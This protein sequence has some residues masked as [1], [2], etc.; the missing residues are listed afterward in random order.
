MDPRI[1][2]LYDEYTHKPL[3]R[4]VFLQRLAVLAGGTAA[5][6]TMLPLLENNYA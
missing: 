5:A 1:I 3:E 6:M 2:R 4:R